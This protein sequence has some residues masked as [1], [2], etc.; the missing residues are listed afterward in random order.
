LSVPGFVD[1]GQ[2]ETQSH[3]NDNCQAIT[4]E[5]C[6]ECRGVTSVWD[7]RTL[8]KERGDFA[9]RLASLEMRV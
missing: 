3:R 2:V 1:E 5:N 6:L 8:S 4:D 7:V 9:N